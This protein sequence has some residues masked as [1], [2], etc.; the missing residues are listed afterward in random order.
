[1]TKIVSVNIRDAKHQMLCVTSPRST[2]GMDG[3]GELI[4]L[5]V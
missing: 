4:W 2:E 1:M 5:K 3:E